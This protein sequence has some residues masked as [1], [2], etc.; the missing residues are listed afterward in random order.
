MLWA[1]CWT[2]FYCRGVNETVS[3]S[4]EG[5]KIKWSHKK[6]RK[7][8]MKMVTRGGNLVPTWTVDAHLRQCPDRSRCVCLCVRV[9]VCTFPQPALLA[10]QLTHQCCQGSWHFSVQNIY[11][12]LCLLPPASSS[13]SSVSIFPST[14]RSGKC[15]RKS[16]F[17]LNVLVLLSESP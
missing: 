1:E 3:P 6:Y 13:S 7:S 10:V 2:H 14:L 16:I 4:R 12:Y 17:T 5:T 15:S 8:T 9:C 11:I